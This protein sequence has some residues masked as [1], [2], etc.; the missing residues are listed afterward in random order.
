MESKRVLEIESKKYKGD[1]LVVS[2]R[3]PSELVNDIDKIVQKT[4]R[5]R[6]EIILM[7]L[8]FALENIVVP[9]RK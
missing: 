6:N 4:G 3:L 5:T 1:T 7:C 2:F 8:D 9:E